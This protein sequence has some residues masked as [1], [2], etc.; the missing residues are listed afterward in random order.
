MP[1]THLSTRSLVLAAAL[2]AGCGGPSGG[3]GAAGEAAAGE[4][5]PGLP[6]SAGDSVVR[7]VREAAI[8]LTGGER[9]YDALMAMV[10]DAR[11]VL[12]GEATH[13]T[14][15]FYRERARITR[16]LIEEKGF[17][18][19]VIEGDW[20]D[21]ERVHRY[22]RGE[23]GA[24]E[25]VL[26]G[27][28]TRFPLWMW[29]NED[30]RA[31]AEWMRGFNARVDPSRQAGFYGMD[32]YS[33]FTSADDVVRYLATV[34]PAAAERARGR[35]RCFDRY[36]DD[37]QAY[38]AAVSA[39]PDRSCEA[40]TQEQVQE[41]E[42]R[43]A[44]RP[45]G[46]DARAADALFSALQNAHAVENA[47]DYFRHLYLGGLSTWNLRDQHMAETLDRLVRHLESQGKTP[48]VVVWAHNTHSGDARVTEMGQQGG[49][50]NVGQL[51]RERYAERA[52]L[53]GFTTYAG[54]VLA[55]E[56]WDQPG[57]VRELRPALP[58]SYSGLF[59]RTGIPA[60]L[61]PFRGRPEVSRALAGPRLERAVGVIYL[62]R[63]ERASH[64]F[65][66]HMPRQFDAV[67]HVDSTTAI[68]PLRR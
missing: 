53:V 13:G 34:D 31:L 11:F 46:M 47:E 32:V 36:R 35:Y 20:P 21:A 27:A 7:L 48:K 29:A 1:R 10:G 19:M 55:A 30:V 16:R 12:L 52:V 14:H 9:D 51:M 57:R 6:A 23:A 66:A 67:I 5:R 42:A 39:S 68:T 33:L 61:L 3:G 56:E 4:P 2:L 65:T 28:F 60:F 58:E 25:A 62:P 54:T 59:H 40:R 24:P 49:E 38:G 44:A 37:P 41:M 45:S 50:H 8:P 64:Y 26:T 15:E 17:T 22:V 63:T 43:Y 18:G